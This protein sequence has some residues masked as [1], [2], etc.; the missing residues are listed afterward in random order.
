MIF[1]FQSIMN[2]QNFYYSFHIRQ[3]KDVNNY[4][5]LLAGIV[6]YGNCIS[7]KS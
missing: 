6:E 1:F 2:H 5:T 7:V 3:N 4:F